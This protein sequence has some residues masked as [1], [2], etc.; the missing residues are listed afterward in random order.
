MRDDMAT[1]EGDVEQSADARS[2]AAPGGPG[3][4]VLGPLLA[5]LATGFPPGPDDAA[6]LA[7]LR[8][9]GLVDDRGHVT[10]LGVHVLE[11]D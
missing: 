6:G 9:R 1:V 2:S 8:G 10:T 7:A 3:W 4:S 5:R 11:D